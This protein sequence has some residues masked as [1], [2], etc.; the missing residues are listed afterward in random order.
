MGEGAEEP[1]LDT[2]IHEAH[3]VDVDAHVVMDVLDRVLGHDHDARHV[4]GDAR[5]HFHEPVPAAHAPALTCV[6]RVLHLETAVDGDRMVQGD[7]RGDEPF[8]REKAVTEALVVVDD[9]E[10]RRP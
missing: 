6:R 1:R 4:T 3:A 2:D 9:V 8:D 7:D 10:L 5:L